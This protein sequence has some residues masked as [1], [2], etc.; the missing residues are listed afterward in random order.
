[1]RRFIW[2]AAASVVL[3]LTLIP[4]TQARTE[5]WEE[6]FFRANQ[7]YKEGR[8]KEAVDKYGQ[9]VRSGYV[10][11]HLYYNLGN[12]YFR[13]N[14]IG[15]AILFY[16]RARLLM[17]RD[18]DLAFNLQNARDH[19]HDAIA[20][21]QDFI[22]MTFFWLD[23]LGLDEMFQGFVVLNILFWAILLIRLCVRLEWTYYLFLTFMIFWLIALFSFGLK[24]V[25]DGTDDRAV[26]LQE[27]VSVKAGPDKQDTVLFKLHQGTIVHYERSE[28]GWALV[29]LPDKK[30][31]WVKADTI[32]RIKDS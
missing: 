32:E 21:S 15:R 1:V 11:G 22:S 10:N 13:M 31:G 9:L 24:W 20:E 25:Q 3:L 28:D 5:G 23:S 12:A 17:P 14:Q 29:H 4:D 18:P 19:T 16:E 8:F 26:I 30:R 6:L 2:T 7:A 27:E